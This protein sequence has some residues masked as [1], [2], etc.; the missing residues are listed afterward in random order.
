MIACASVCL[1]VADRALY[2]KHVHTHQ[3]VECFQCKHVISL[4]CLFIRVTFMAIASYTPITLHLGVSTCNCTLIY[5]YNGITWSVGTTVLLWSA[6]TKVVLA[7]LLFLQ[8]KEQFHVLKCS[9]VG[10]ATCWKTRYSSQTQ[11]SLACELDY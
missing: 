3:L 5:T 9:K 11:E 1:F 4:T 2:T 6:G 10:V 7:I 8:I